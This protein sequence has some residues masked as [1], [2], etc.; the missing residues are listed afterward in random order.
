M[1]TL[2]AQNRALPRWGNRIALGIE[3]LEVEQWLKELKSEEGLA[4]PTLDRIRRVMSLVYRH[5]QRHGLI[6]R[7]YESNPMRVTAITTRSLS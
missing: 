6:P 7:R 2:I 1:A 3:P 4:N 5:G